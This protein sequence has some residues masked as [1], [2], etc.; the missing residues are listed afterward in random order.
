MDDLAAG[1]PF[2]ILGVAEDAD[3]ATIRQAYLRLLRRHPP[4]RDPDGFRRLRA[5]Y[6]A[7]RSLQDRTARRLLEKP[8]LPDVEPLLR[9][10]AEEPIP[11][12]QAQIMNVLRAAVVCALPQLQVLETDLRAIPDSLPKEV[13][14]PSGDSAV[15]E[16]RRK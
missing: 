8:V 13:P 14:P 6:E 3:D 7:V 10:L 15:I 2:E 16:S 5:A 4:E 12:D 11:R 1:N 9:A